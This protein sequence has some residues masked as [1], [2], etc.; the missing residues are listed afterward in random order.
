MS[1]AI[2]PRIGLDVVMAPR[3]KRKPYEVSGVADSDGALA[4]QGQSNMHTLSLLTNVP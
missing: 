3:R 1:S 2:G 4:L